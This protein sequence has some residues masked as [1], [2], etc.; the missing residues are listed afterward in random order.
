[1]AIL[2]RRHNMHDVMK[3]GTPPTV[4]HWHPDLLAKAIDEARAAIQAIREP[5][6]AMLSAVDELCDEPLL[7]E[8]VY[9]AMIDAALRE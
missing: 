7:P 3:P 9:R 5:T 8:S 6:E 1:M 4:A 2:W